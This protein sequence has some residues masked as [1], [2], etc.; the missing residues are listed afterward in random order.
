MDAD[1]LAERRRD[2]VRE[3]AARSGFQRVMYY[4]F[5][6]DEDGD[7]E[8]LAEARQAEIYGSYL[9]LRFPASDIPRVART[10]YV[11]NSW[12]LIPDARAAAVPVLGTGRRT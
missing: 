6:E 10:L 7:G 8:V 3:V 12:R 1:T 9:G 11:R 5:R 2:L 4:R